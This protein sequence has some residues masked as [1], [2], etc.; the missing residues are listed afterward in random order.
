M[1]TRAIIKPM[2]G[3]QVGA[4]TKPGGL[5]G[6]LKQ[7]VGALSINFFAN[8]LFFFALVIGFLHG[9]LKMRYPHPLMTFAYDIP[10]ALALVLVLLKLKRTEKLFPDSKV[11]R[12]IQL[13][14]GL[15]L[16][17]ALLPFGVPW[18]VRLSSFR[19]W[20]FAPLMML[21]GY[22]LIRSVRQVEVFVW[23]MIVLG[24]GT[25]V[26]GVFFQSEAEIRSM[27][28]LDADLSTRLT[29]SFYANSQGTAFRHF[30]TYVT[31]AVFGSVM[32]ICATFAISRVLVPGGS[33]VERAGLL[34]CAGLCS[35]ALVLT[36]SRTSMALLVLGMVLS[37][38]FS[39]GAA[40]VLV[41]PV[42]LA[43][44]VAVGVSLVGGAAAERFGSLLD[45]AAVWG[46]IYIVVYPMWS[47]MLENPLGGGLGRSGHGVPF[48]FAGFFRDF[49]FRGTDGDIGRVMADFG[50]PGVV[51]YVVLIYSAVSD[52]LRWMWRLRDSNLSIIAAPAGSML[53]LAMAQV[54]TGSPFLG[55][56][57]G[58]LVWIMFGG[59]RRMVEEYERKA[60]IEGDAVEDLPEFVSFITR[61]RIASVFQGAPVQLTEN[62]RK[63][64][65][66]ERF[67]QVGVAPREA[68]MATASRAGKPR[69]LFR[70][71][72]RKIK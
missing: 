48:S 32:A 71:E 11:S 66:R 38:G 33:W 68:P 45:P 21:L 49:E 35:Y 39:R 43:I 47:M 65:V 56:P 52:A 64:P 37:A 16:L 41:L 40:R 23:L 69:F 28:A 24:T 62:A 34:A 3:S 2:L 61:K 54:F 51:V 59:L 70:R 29:G 4:G 44:P 31:A 17:Y 20:C 46:R 53:L 57:A 58:M 55:I 14:L 8:A 5:A 67:V 60:A 10:M 25:A 50:M 19:G 63:R 42:L 12:A 1:A 27:M 18:L 22:H 15:S 72:P 13:L 30:S 9:W 36:G 26:Y 6:I 7:V